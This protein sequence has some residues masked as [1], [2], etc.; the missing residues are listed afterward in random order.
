V[1]ELEIGEERERGDREARE[2]RE[3]KRDTKS[4]QGMGNTIKH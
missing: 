1:R 3:R 2:E 4:V